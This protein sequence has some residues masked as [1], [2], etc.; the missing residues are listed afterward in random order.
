MG[1][2]FILLLY[3]VVFSISY[4]VAYC[5]GVCVAAEQQLPHDES[6]YFGAN[7]QSTLLR[8]MAV[9]MSWIFF[10]VLGAVATGATAILTKAGLQ[11]VDSNLGL[12]I[13]SVIILVLT[14]LI[15]GLSGQATRLLEIP[16]QAWMF[17]IGAGFMTT[18]AYLCYF[19]ALE[20]GDASR[21]APID[22]LSLVVS[23]ALGAL[24]LREKLSAPLLI[25]AT[26]MVCGAIVIAMSPSK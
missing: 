6:K 12:A 18:F 17:L 10:A 24:V 8:E 26:L 11:K 9:F 1:T 16:R 2:G 23:I 20:L 13:Q 5:Y 7:R 14:W 15:V 25:G 21:V 22:R 3:Q 19:K 4:D